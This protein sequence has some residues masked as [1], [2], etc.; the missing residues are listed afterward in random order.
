MEI[1]ATS[2]STRTGKPGQQCSWGTS[3]VSLPGPLKIETIRVTAPNNDACQRINV[4][5]T[6]P[7][8]D[9]HGRQCQLLPL[10]GGFI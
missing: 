5:M 7:Q 6:A 1:I 4:V 9:A 10:R 8:Q 2:L 3:P